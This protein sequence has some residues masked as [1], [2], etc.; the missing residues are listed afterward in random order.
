[1]KKPLTIAFKKLLSAAISGAEAT[2]KSIA[3]GARSYS[4]TQIEK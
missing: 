1:M 2:Q 3:P 4:E